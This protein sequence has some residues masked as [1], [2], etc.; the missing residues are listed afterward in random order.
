M[1][2]ITPVHESRAGPNLI[3]LRCV[4]ESWRSASKPGR[5]PLVIDASNRWMKA[6][7]ELTIYVQIGGF[8]ACV[9]F[10][11]VTNLTVD[12]IL[13]TTFVGRHMKSFLP[14]Q[15]KAHRNVK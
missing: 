11:V 7:G 13:G 14:P 15:R 3:H 1:R 9:Q 2:A 8:V 5:S 4:A 6:L 10:L 12:C